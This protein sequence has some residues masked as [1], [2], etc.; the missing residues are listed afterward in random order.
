MG[1]NAIVLAVNGEKVAVP[2]SFNP[3]HRLID[4]L[5]SETRFTVRGM[6]AVQQAQ[7]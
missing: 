2:S 3:S 4:V 6:G 1:T 5:R 7:L